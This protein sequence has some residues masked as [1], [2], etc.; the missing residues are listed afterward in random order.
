MFSPLGQKSRGNRNRQKGIS[1]IIDHA[2][3]AY[4]PNPSSKHENNHGAYC[5]HENIAKEMFHS[6]ALVPLPLPTP[7]RLLVE[8]S[9][10][11]DLCY[12]PISMGWVKPNRPK[13]TQLAQ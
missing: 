13:T 11:K 8:Y 1:Q 7:D 12:S 9:T 3:S 10:T 2:T 5:S 6:N 4:V